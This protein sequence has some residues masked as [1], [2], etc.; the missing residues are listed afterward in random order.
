LIYLTP[1]FVSLYILKW[2]IN[3]YLLLV[4]SVVYFIGALYQFPPHISEWI[5]AE[6]EAKSLGMMMP[7]IEEG[8][9]A[10]GL[11]LCG[12]TLLGYFFYQRKK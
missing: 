10:A 4:A 1:A 2:R 3:P 9:E 6:E 8:R 5:S 7:G 12:V 11:F